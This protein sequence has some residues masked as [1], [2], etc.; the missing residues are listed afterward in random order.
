MFEFTL[1]E[2]FL[3]MLMRFAICTLVNW[4]IIDRLYYRKSHRRDF[5]FTFM[6]MSTAIF[7]LV[8]FMIFVLDDLKGK[9]GIGIG[10]GLFGIFS[11]MRY[12]TETMPVRELTYL[13]VV[14]TLAVVNALAT[15]IPLCETLI[16]NIVILFAV[17]LCE[18]MLK[19]KPTKLIQY[20]RIELIKPECRQQLI[21]DLQQRLGI[22]V[23]KVEVGSVDMLRDMAILKVTYNDNGDGNPA[24]INNKLKLKSEDLT[25]V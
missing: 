19:A 22:Q 2:D 13:F 4:I 6:L 18:M 25:Q 23:I 5:Y 12:R 11:I 16:T 17:C 24:E 15:N 3:L 7:F 10:I 9:T 14:I 21:D 1:Q 20:D 8:F